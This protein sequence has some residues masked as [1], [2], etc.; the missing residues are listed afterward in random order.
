M[1]GAGNGHL[2]E[3]FHELY[4]VNIKRIVNLWAFYELLHDS[5]NVAVLNPRYK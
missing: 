3:S 5:G 4:A 2:A 1:Q